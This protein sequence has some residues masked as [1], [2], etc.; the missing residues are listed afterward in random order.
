MSA[1]HS[2]RLG[3]YLL[4]HRLAVGGMGEV[5]VA[6]RP[7]ASAAKP[8]VLKLL[9][10]HLND[11]EDAVAGFLQEAK[12]VARMNHPN[13]VQI[14]DLGLESG[15]YFLAMELVRGVSMTALMKAMVAADSRPSEE[16]ILHVGRALCAGLHHA[17]EQRG[18]NGP[19]ELVHRD[20]TPRNVLL[21]VDGEVK[22]IDFGIAKGRESSSRTPS[23]FVKGTLG[24]LAPEQI[25]LRKVDRRTDVYAAGVTL[26]H[27]ATL[28]PPLQR[29]SKA[30]TYRAIQEEPLPDLAMVR[31][32]LS[33]PLAEA[34]ARATAKDPEARFSTAR[35][36]EEALPRP[37]EG[38]RAR[39]GA[40]VR[41]LCGRDVDQL[42]AKAELST[43]LLTL[44]LT[45]ERSGLTGP[46]DAATIIQAVPSSPL[47][48]RARWLVAVAASLG[49]AAAAAIIAW[50]DAEPGTSAAAGSGLPPR[51]TAP[52][53]GTTRPGGVSRSEGSTRSE[54]APWPDEPAS[55]PRTPPSVAA[56]SSESRSARPRAA[57][58]SSG[59]SVQGSSARLHT[60]AAA[61]DRGE[62]F[63]TVDAV[64]WANVWLGGRAIG[65]TP[66]DSYPA[67]VGTHNVLLVNPETGK[68][69]TRRVKVQQG[70]TAFL[71]VDLR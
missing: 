24:Y 58:P 61:A 23:G 6:A 56:G 34:I 37:S 54:S 26:F 45:G 41:A 40:M 9:L 39:L 1:P 64:P 62:G 35:E 12:H 13:V 69:A 47:R 42:D 2:E 52:G 19:L 49:I 15:R 57:A 65:E 4:G 67:P 38:A 21:S 59:T 20:V 22:L 70:K 8:L 44:E 25:Q 43:S 5:Y 28:V 14:L 51:S 10:P 55:G 27:F 68:R 18:P 66:I 29:G 60:R 53:A 30:E 71:K 7:G 48:T 32:G 33:K 36:L 63:L 3:K 50:P 17:H 46:V 11:D 31:P 16:V